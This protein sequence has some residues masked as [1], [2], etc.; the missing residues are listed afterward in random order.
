MKNGY[1]V[2]R[3][4]SD[5]HIKSVKKLIKDKV[6]VVESNGK[7]EGW[8][9]DYYINNSI[10]K[11]TSIRKYRHT[12]E[13]YRDDLKYAYEI[14]VIVDMTNTHHNADRYGARRM[15]SMVRGSLLRRVDDELKYFGIDA[16]RDATISKINFQKGSLI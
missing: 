6:Y 15:G 12:N 9:F 7:P 4:I 8:I 2:G 11:I 3:A 14:D 1:K 10:I 5:N 13:R 16:W